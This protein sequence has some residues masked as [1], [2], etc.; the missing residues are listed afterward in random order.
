MNDIYID[1]PTVNFSDRRV[2]GEVLSASKATG[3]LNS[4]SGLDVWDTGTGPRTP[5]DQH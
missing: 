3:G 5:H 1:D 4:S 2:V